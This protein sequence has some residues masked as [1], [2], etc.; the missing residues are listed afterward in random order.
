VSWRYRSEVS[1]KAEHVSK[2]EAVALAIS[3]ARKD[4]AEGRCVA[5]L[6]ILDLAQLW[7]GVDQQKLDAKMARINQAHVVVSESPQGE[8]ERVH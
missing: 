3:Q 4:L 2:Q 6:D 1:A 5:A 7:L 8:I